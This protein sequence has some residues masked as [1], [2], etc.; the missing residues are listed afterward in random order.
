MREKWSKMLSKLLYAG[1]VVAHHHPPAGQKDDV[2]ELNLKTRFRFFFRLSAAGGRS[3]A[4]M[5]AWGTR[6]GNGGGS[7]RG[8]LEKDDVEVFV[9][10]G[11]A[12]I[13]CS[14][15]PCP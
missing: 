8:E 3:T 7:G 9:P 5:Q 4:C 1:V 12:R 6:G 10:C 14:C 15:R 2:P 11:A 13:R